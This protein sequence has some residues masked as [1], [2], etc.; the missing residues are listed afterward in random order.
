MSRSEVNRL[1]EDVTRNPDEWQ[2]DKQS[3]MA[4]YDLTDEERTALAAGDETQ[5][6]SIGVDERLNKLRRNK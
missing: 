3:V 4:R 5:L 2:R 6:R 1:L